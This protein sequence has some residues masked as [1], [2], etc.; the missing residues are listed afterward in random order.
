MVRR[1][2]WLVGQLPV[3]MIDDGFFLRFV[4]LF[5]DLATGLLEG[6]DNIPN[7]VDV[8]VA[9]PSMVRWL[10]SWIGIDNIDS[11]LPVDLQR[12]IVEESAQI[13]A[14]RGTRRGLVQWLELMT[15]GKVEVADSGGVYPAGEV[16]IRAAQV[17]IRVESTGWVPENDFVAL[18]RDEIP[19]NVAF[20]VHVRDRRLWPPAFQVGAPSEG[21]QTLAPPVAVGAGVGVG[22]GTDGGFGGWWPRGDPG[23]GAWSGGDGPTWA[24]GAFDGESHP[25]MG[26]APATAP[27]PDGPG[28]AGGPDLADPAPAGPA[29]AAGPVLASGA[30]PPPNAGAWMSAP[31]PAPSPPPP[32]PATWMPSPPPAPANGPP[33]PPPPSGW[34]PPPPP[35]SGWTPPPPPAGMPPAPPPPPPS[36]WMPPAPG[37]TDPEAGEGDQEPPTPGAS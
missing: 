3:G 13:L 16:G 6:V 11:S 29:P 21:S 7:S 10:G 1:S 35:P 37:T 30:W 20:E 22:S 19:A 14:W 25:G 17:W 24:G 32:P 18:L 2:D 5:Q 31:G 27:A 8:T 23:G 36:G 4:R 12:R 15:E 28:L 26:P 9:P 33:P 34:T